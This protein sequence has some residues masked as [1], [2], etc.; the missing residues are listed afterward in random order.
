[1]CRDTGGKR[2]KEKEGNGGKEQTKVGTGIKEEREE[3]VKKQ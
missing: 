1:M 3:A 2:A